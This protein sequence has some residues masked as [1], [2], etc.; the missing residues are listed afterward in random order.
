MNQSFLVSGTSA[1][2][3]YVS[4]TASAQRAAGKSASEAEEFIRQA[5]AVKPPAKK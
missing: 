4:G 2:T 3:A 5:L 1:A